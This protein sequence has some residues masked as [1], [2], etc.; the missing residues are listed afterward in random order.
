MIYL[1]NAATTLHKPPQV[2]FRRG[3]GH[4]NP[5]Q[6]CPGC[7]RKF[8]ASLPDDLRHPVRSG[9][10]LGFSHPERVIFT[11][12]ATESLNL[13]LNGLF[14]PGD[15]VITTDLE[16]NSVL[17]P[18]YRLEDQ[19][20]ITLDFVPAD[21]MG[22]PDYSA[23]EDLIRPNTRAHCH[24]PRLQPH[25][26]SGGFAPGQRH[27]QSHGLLLVVDASQTAGSIP[28]SM[29]DLGIDLPLASPDTRG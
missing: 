6:R 24:H 15:H 26:K 4:A 18:L 27:R 10:A 5:G 23:F 13:A 3:G 28:I 1:D 21:R 20:T 12:N 29:E 16:H 19:G 22:N 17:R 25:R 8:P 2:I 14:S 9:P 11:A 7:P